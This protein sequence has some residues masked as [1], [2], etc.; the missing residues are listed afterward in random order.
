MGKYCSAA[1]R[2]LLL[3]GATSWPF[4]FVVDSLFSVPVLGLV[5]FRAPNKADKGNRDH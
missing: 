1:L 4:D 3:V 2:L 5:Y